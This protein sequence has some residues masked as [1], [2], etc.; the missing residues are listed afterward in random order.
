MNEPKLVK[1]QPP[2][3]DMRKFNGLNRMGPDAKPNGAGRPVGSK[4]KIGTD[5][6]KAILEAAAELG[7]D[8]QGA[9]GLVGYLKMLGANY[10]QTYASLLHRM[11]PLQMSADVK[12]GVTAVNIMPV[13]SGMYASADTLA[14][15][16]YDPG[17]IIE[18]DEDEGEAS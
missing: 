2:K 17:P 4:D 9:E 18:H 13:P 7:R 11:I 6:K 8:G 10:P 15:K 14:G 16:L 12:G 3:I 1:L 5:L